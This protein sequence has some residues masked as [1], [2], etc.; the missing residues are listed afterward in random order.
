LD[1]DLELFLVVQELLTGK[2]KSYW[3]HE[4]LDWDRHVEKLVHEDCF[5]IR[6]HMP[7]D[8]FEALVELLGDVIVPNIVQSNTRCDEP[9]YPKMVAPI[10]I[11][12]LAGGNYDDI[13]NTFGTSKGEFYWSRNKCINAVLNCNSLD[14]DIP[15]TPV[16]WEKMRKGFA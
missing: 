4:S 3:E 5:H 8:D 16:E 11:S 10:G 7:L 9:I 1:G 13:M 14:I 12:I 2:R 15:T 6:Y